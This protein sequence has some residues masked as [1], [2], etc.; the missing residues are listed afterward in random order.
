MVPTPASGWLPVDIGFD[1]QPAAVREALVR[2]ME[3]GSTPLAEPFLDDTV[4]R[5][6]GANPAAR[7]ID[8]DLETMVRVASRAPAVVPA[9]FIV[10]LSH[11][12]STLIANALKT[13]GNAVVVSESRAITRLLRNNGN[14]IHSYLRERWDGTRRTLLSAMFNLFARYR[15]GQTEPLVIK[16]VSLDILSMRAI[17]SYWPEVPCAVVIR[18]P[19]EVMVTSLKGG[20]WMTFKKHPETARGLFGWTDLSRSA[21]EMTD[22]EYCARALGRFCASALESIDANCMVVDYAELN[23]K[24]MREIGDFFGIG[25][26]NTAEIFARYAKDPAKEIQFRDDQEWKQKLATVFMRSAANQWAMDSY[27]QLRGWKP[28]GKL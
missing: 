16:F 4:D 19:V 17:R 14:H 2:W 1:S 6:R 28:P 18:D 12:G 13:S 7:E 5:L 15:T 11:C 9:G 21:A 23:P 24:R 8:T 27:S 3:F 20:G 26:G 22:E 25:M 10:H